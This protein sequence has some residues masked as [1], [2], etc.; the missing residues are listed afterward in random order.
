MEASAQELVMEEARCDGG[1]VWLEGGRSQL[2]GDVRL[3]MAATAEGRCNAQR[4][5]MQL[6]LLCEAWRPGSCRAAQARRGVNSC[7]GGR[8]GDP[9][10]L[11]RCAEA[12]DPGAD[13]GR[14]Q[15][16]PGLFKDHRVLCSGSS[17]RVGELGILETFLL[18]SELRAS[19]VDK[20]ALTSEQERGVNGSGL[21]RAL[22]GLAQARF[23]KSQPGPGPGPGV[24]PAGGPGHTKPKPDPIFFRAGPGQKFV[25]GLFFRPK[26][27]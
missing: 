15:E 22:L 26:P 17:L 8:A 2:A 16:G 4:W 7:E 20:N 13:W 21:D 25:T 27:S 19:A 18:S 12:G 23:Y 10:A 1:A 3:V 6:D 11:S 9:G 24:G 14:K 5:R